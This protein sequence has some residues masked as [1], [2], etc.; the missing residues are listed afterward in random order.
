MEILVIALGS[1][2]MAGVLFFPLNVWLR[3]RERQRDRDLLLALTR[4]RLDVIKTALSMGYD[5]LRLEELDGRLRQ[6]LS[7]EQY[8]QLVENIRITDPNAAQAAANAQ[9][10]AQAATAAAS[11]AA[12]SAADASQAAVGSL[13]GQDLP[14]AS[15]AEVR[16]RAGRE[17]T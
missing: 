15:A 5:Q 10:A 7:E 4:E 13:L 2:S 16:A 9:N 8:L 3:N 6:M 11:G 17:Q 12:S 1:I 14:A